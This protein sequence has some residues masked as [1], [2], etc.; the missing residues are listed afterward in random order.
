MRSVLESNQISAFIHHWFALIFGYKQKGEE[1][2]YSLN[3]FQ[4]SNNHI[5]LKSGKG[6]LQ[7][8]AFTE[9]Q[10]QFGTIPTHLFSEPHPQRVYRDV[11]EG[12]E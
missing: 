10:S 1:A 4:A 11:S 12:I 9:L 3:C 8:E 6:S 7:F 2:F 5:D